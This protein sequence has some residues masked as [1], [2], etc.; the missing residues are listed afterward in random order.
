MD[1]ALTRFAAG[2]DFPLDDFQRRACEYLDDEAGVL[3][4]EVQ[5]DELRREVEVL[6]AV[7]V[8]EAGTLTLGDGQRVDL[9]LRRPGVEDVVAVVRAHL[10]LCVVV[11]EA[12]RLAIEIDVV[13]H[14]RILSLI[15]ARNLKNGKPREGCR[16]SYRA[17]PA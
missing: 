8:P 9:P 12:L 6:V 2:Y 14:V 16:A 11:A 17:A 10:A 5:V 1:S 15:N 13:R 3:V 7:V 4:A